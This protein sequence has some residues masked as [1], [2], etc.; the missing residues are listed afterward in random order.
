MPTTRPLTDKELRSAKRFR[1]LAPALQKAIRK[2]VRGR[3]AGTGKKEAV[4]I[5]L[6]KDVVAKLRA[7]GAGWQTRLNDMLRT[8]MDLWA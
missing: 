5:S 7:S 6:D 2:S 4:T 8:T 1:D 3:P